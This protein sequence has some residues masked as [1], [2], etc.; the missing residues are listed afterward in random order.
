MCPP[1][2]LAA[3]NSKLVAQ[4]RRDA[5]VAPGRRNAWG[6]QYRSRARVETYFRKRSW[7]LQQRGA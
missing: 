5:N 7:S 6:R 3:S 4:M 2:G 1:F